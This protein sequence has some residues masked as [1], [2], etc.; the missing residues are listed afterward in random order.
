MQPV[1]QV[2][3]EIGDESAT[4]PDFTDPQIEL[5]LNGRGGN[6]LLAA[7][8]LCD[9]LAT[10][11]AREFD[12]SSA[13]RQEF[14]RSQKAESMERRA[15]KLRE[16][17]GGLVAVPTTRIDGFSE[18]IDNRSGAGQSSRT[19]RVREGYYDPDIPS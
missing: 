6:I 16:R 13:A 14:K 4:E 7:A 3:F 10:R 15:A 1:E 12:F 2:R 9:I 8:D 11:Y 18:D 17:A 5:K 19:G